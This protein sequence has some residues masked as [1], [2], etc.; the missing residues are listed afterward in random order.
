[1]IA[2]SR[3]IQLEVCAAIRALLA[4]VPP[5]TASVQQRANYH[6]RKAEV[7][8]FV[9]V[10]DPGLTIPAGELANRARQEA[11]AFSAYEH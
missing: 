3:V 10:A 2:V 7:L 11:H 8:D 9:S 6:I 1:M 4:S 5:F